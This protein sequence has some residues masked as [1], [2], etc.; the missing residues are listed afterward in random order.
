MSSIV[1][2]EETQIEIQ[3]QQDDEFDE[4]EQEPGEVGWLEKHG[5]KVNK[6]R[7]N[8]KNKTKEVAH[9]NCNY[10]RKVF[11]GP[12]LHLKSSHLKICLIGK[13]NGLLLL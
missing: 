12:S 6:A 8:G 13:R 4:L 5:R 11:V 9:F 7:A 3:E 1:E 2:E 10:C